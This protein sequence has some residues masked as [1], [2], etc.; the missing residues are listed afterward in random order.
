MND[1]KVFKLHIGNDLGISHRWYSW[2]FLVERL[3]SP[4]LGLALR[5]TLMSEE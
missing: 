3:K 2:G 5:L 1:H 4:R